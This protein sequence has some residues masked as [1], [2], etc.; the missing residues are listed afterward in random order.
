M[1]TDL[2]S[3]PSQEF[4][5]GMEAVAAQFDSATYPQQNL[6]ADDWTQPVKS[7]VLLPALPR[8]YGERDMNQA[9]RPGARR[10]RY[11]GLSKTRLEHAF[12]AVA[13]NFIRL[14]TYWTGTPSTAGT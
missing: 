8:E 4:T 7:G 13:P 3:L 11:R 10:A 12:T 14:H 5:V 9:V 6:P 2:L 1:T